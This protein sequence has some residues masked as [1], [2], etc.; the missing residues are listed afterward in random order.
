[1]IHSSRPLGHIVGQIAHVELP[2]KISYKGR[3]VVL[4][5][6]NPQADVDELYECSHGSYVT[7]LVWTYMGYGPFNSKLCMQKWL[8]EMAKSNDPLFFTVRI[9]KLSNVLGW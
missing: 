4:S 1:M 5:P 8:E 2:R 6:V 3:F 9:A 7:E